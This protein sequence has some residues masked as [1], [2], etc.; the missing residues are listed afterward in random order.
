M[1]ITEE[2]LK[3]SRLFRRLRNDTH[4]QLVELFAVRL[5]EVGLSRQGT[6]RSLNVV[7][8]LLDWMARHRTKLAELDERMVARYLR[9]QAAKKCIQLGDLAA[10]KRWLLTL[11][12]AGTIVPAAISP[13]TPHEQIFANFG[14]YLHSVSGGLNPRKSGGGKR[15]RNLVAPFGVHFWWRVLAAAFGAES[16]NSKGPVRG[17]CC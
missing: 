11:R 15:W 17:P 10:L 3:R 13:R 7:G 1:T 8:D 12:D 16:A 5:V 14:D 6:W 9:H 2:Y 4:G